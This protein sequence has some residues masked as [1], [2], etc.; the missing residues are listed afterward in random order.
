MEVNYI[1]KRPKKGSMTAYELSPS[2]VVLSKKKQK[3]KS[4]RVGPAA[5]SMSTNPRE[6]KEKERTQSI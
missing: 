3:K 1:I 6:K 4:E 2:G 5:A